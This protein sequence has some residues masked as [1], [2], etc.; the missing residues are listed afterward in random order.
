MPV[1]PFRRRR[2]TIA[3]LAPLAMAMAAPAWADAPAAHHGVAFVA[4][5]GVKARIVEPDA[6][7]VTTDGVSDLVA[8]AS[9]ASRQAQH[10]IARLINAEAADKGLE[11]QTLPDTPGSD[12]ARPPPRR[13]ANRGLRFGSVTPGV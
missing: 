7:I 11:A 6:R 3:L 8:P 5:K 13:E 12:A 10:A 2:P 9:I 4:P 1:P